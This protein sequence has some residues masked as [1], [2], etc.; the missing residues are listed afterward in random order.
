[1]VLFFQIIE[2]ALFIWVMA[3]IATQVAIP[4]MKNRKL[5]PAFRKEDRVLT[6]EE[7]EVATAL[8]RE[9]RK[10][11]INAQKEKKE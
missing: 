4:L 2:V 10:A 8:D 9:L 7:V 5:F 1:M 6:E 3:F 11:R